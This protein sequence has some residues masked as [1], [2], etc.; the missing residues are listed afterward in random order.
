VP[1]RQV[2]DVGL[3]DLVARPLTAELPSELVETA[4]DDLLRAGTKTA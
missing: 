4:A 2:L 1:V 3:S